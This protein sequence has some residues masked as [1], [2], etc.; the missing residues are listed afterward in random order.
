MLE[1]NK[2]NQNFTFWII[3]II[4][5]I[6]YYFYWLFYTIQFHPFDTDITYYSQFFNSYPILYQINNEGFYPVLYLPFFYYIFSIF[7]QIDPISLFLIINF[8]S[9]FCILFSIFLTIKYGSYLE[10][11]I[12]IIFITLS[13]GIH[14]QFANLE[15]IV[16]F[17]NIYLYYSLNSHQSSK[18]IIL[19]AFLF[20]LFSFKI[21][22]IIF[23]ILFFQKI[24]KKESKYLFFLSFL[25]FEL[26]LNLFWII[27]NIKLINIDFLISIIKYSP[28]YLKNCIYC[29]ITRINIFIPLSFYLLNIRKLFK[30][31]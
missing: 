11:W 22:S 10:S 24:A 25:L 17:P 29:W 8:L 16:L 14:I 3:S 19:F 20:T 23:L 5:L 26:I 7:A 27:Q 4:I 18:R 21:Y 6:F 2:N 28:K 31:L 15:Y 1:K 9:L 13:I 30:K 12:L